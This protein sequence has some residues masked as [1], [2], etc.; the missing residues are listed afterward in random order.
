MQGANGGARALKA[1]PLHQ[2][3]LL[4]EV[5]AA[6]GPLHPITKQTSRNAVQRH[7]NPQP[8]VVVLAWRDVKQ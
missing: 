4:V 1:L 2:A 6:A 3:L 8:A 5:E 7:P